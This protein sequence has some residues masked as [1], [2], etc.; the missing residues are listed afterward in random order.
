MEPSVFIQ[1]VS[2]RTE[3][4]SSGETK[5]TVAFLEEFV[6]RSKMKDLKDYDDR[7]KVLSFFPVAIVLVANASHDAAMREFHSLYYD[8]VL[9]TENTL[10][11]LSS[12]PELER[13]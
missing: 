3:G 1:K 6:K 10:E 5:D 11:S 4:R 2:V 12:S 7:D 8:R 13:L 9:A